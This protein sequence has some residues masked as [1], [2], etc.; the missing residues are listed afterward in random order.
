MGYFFFLFHL[1]IVPPC[2]NSNDG[3]LNKVGILKKK[4]HYFGG[5][6]NQVKEWKVQC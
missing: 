6:K 5:K 2:V 4:I 1:R 3:V